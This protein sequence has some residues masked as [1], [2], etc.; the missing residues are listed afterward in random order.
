MQR[1]C[2]KSEAHILRH[3]KR[4]FFCLITVLFSN[5]V[6]LCYA[7]DFRIIT[8]VF[9]VMLLS[10]AFILFN[11]LPEYDK[12]SSFRQKALIGGYELLKAAC[13]I[14][15]FQALLY[16]YISFVAGFSVNIPMLVGNGVFSLAVY[17]VLLLNGMIR[18]FILSKQLSLALR[19]CLLFLWWVPG[20]NIIVIGIGCKVVKAEYDFFVKKR[21]LNKARAGK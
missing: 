2:S 21:K 4:A 16:I 17:F 18:V 3:I 11:I 12:Y 15:A 10:V 9:A 5:C 14:F 13:V 8:K 6:Y 19:I 7:A 20:V 1:I